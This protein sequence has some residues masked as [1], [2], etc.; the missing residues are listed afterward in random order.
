MNQYLLYKWDDKENLTLLGEEITDDIWEPGEE[1]SFEDEDEVEKDWLISVIYYSQPRK[2][3]RPNGT[4][5][6]PDPIVILK[7]QE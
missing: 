7:P 5:Y 4:T 2:I 6:V 3:K 1:V